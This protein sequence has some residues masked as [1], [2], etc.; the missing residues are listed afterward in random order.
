MAVHQDDDLL[1]R[2][3]RVYFQPDFSVG[4]Y[5]QTERLFFGLSA[6]M[7]ISHRFNSSTDAFY[8]M[9]DY[10]EYNFFLHAGYL[11]RPT[12]AVKVLPSL[13][14]RF[15]PASKP[16]TDLNLHLILYDRIQTGLS[17]RSN[18]SIIGLFMYHVNNQLAI[19]YSYDMGLGKV[20]GYMGSSHEIMI[21]YDFLYIVDVITP[22]YF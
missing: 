1:M 4:T 7:F 5:Y 10:K 8:M 22:R 14:I 18:K 11:L 13:L 2:D 6:P 9:N 21:R 19:A 12:S 20:G 15:N 17:Y 16:Q 3:S